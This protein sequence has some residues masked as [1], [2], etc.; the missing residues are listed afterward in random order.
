MRWGFYFKF[1]NE[2]LNR[3]S[4]VLFHI[5]E[6]GLVLR[7][8]CAKYFQPRKTKPVLY[9]VRFTEIIN[10]KILKKWNLLKNTTGQ[11]NRD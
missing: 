11:M 4:T 8:L 5:T 6:K 1:L 3:S 10:N 9:A 2:M 7:G